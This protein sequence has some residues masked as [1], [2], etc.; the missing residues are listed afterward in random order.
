MSKREKTSVKDWNSIKDR[1][2][3]IDTDIDAFVRLLGRMA[4]EQD[5][6]EFQKTLQTDTSEG[7]KR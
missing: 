7:S 3:N 6:R 4:A 2:H 1:S 5:Y